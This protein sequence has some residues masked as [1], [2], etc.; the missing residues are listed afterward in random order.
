MSRIFAL[1]L[2]ASLTVLG[3]IPAAAPAG[4]QKINGV[5]STPV[6][7]EDLMALVAAA[8]RLA[9]GWDAALRAVSADSQK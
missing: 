9:N 5:R 3:A 1:V 2:T 8:T 7:A 4:A 6:Y